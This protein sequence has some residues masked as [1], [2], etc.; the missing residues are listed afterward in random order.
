MW[1][2]L[3]S[4]LRYF[5]TSLPPGFAFRLRRFIFFI[6]SFSG[7]CCNGTRN[8]VELVASARR[9]ALSNAEGEV[10]FSEGGGGGGIT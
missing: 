2:D 6:I 9:S 1:H 10:T 5:F 7:R 8:P 4:I 3:I